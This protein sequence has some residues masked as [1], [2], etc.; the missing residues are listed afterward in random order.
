[1]KPP[2]EKVFKNALPAL[3]ALLVKDLIER[4]NLSQLEIARRLGITQPAVSQYL[5]SLRGV[6]H[7]K[8]LLRKKDL[9]KSLR[10]FSDLIAKEEISEDEKL[11]MYCKLCEILRKK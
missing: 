2:C 11:K 6:S 9:M 7:S 8:M 5:R 4:H 10:K 3:R 1:M